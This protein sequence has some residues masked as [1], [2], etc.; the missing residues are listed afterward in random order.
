MVKTQM[1]FFLKSWAGLLKKQDP[2]SGLV[3][4]IPDLPRQAPIEKG[5]GKAVGV[6]PPFREL[7]YPLEIL[8]KAASENQRLSHPA[9]AWPSACR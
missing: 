1:N 3:F 2:C 6:L 7:P 8:T 5:R 4:H 9:A